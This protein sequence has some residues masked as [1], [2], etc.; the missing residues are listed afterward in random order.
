MSEEATKM[1]LS[2]LAAEAMPD[3]S[4][5]IEERDDP[6][7]VDGPNKGWFRGTIVGG[8]ST[9]GGKQ[10]ST[11]DVPAMSGNGRNLILAVQLEND[12][13]MRMNIRFLLNYR[14]SD[15]DPAT[16][17]S[18]REAR[19][20]NGKGSWTINASL[21]GP[22]LSLGKCAELQ[23]AFG[24]LDRHPESKHI[25]ADPFVGRQADI[26]IGLDKDKKY[27][28]VKSFAAKGTKVRSTT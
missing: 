4:E 28:E 3:L 26:R 14:P 21:Q 11:G 6:F 17:E 8:F 24:F 20:A 19:R 1:G 27:K 12:R 25:L 2:G 10:I 9:R 18:I 22:S 23:R 7:P 16:L 13:G 15:V 5:F